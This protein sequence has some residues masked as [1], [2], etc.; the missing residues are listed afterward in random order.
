MEPELERRDDAKIATTSAKGPKEV[1]VACFTRVHEPAVSS[2]DVGGGQI[3][4]AKS[5]TAA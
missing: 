2:Y 4:D 5:V 3:V 1:A